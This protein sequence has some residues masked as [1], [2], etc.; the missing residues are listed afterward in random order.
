MEQG[1]YS[2]DQEA[3]D[4]IIGRGKSSCDSAPGKSQHVEWM[5]PK[6]IRFS[7]RPVFEKS[8]ALLRKGAGKEGS[9][10]CFA[11]VAAEGSLEGLLAKLRDGS[12][13]VEEVPPIR[14]FYHEN[15]WYTLDNR[16]LWVFRELGKRI[17]VEVVEASK[18][19]L[20][21][22]EPK[23]A[24]REVSFRNPGMAAE[25]Q[26]LSRQVLAW[27]LDNINNESLLVNQVD[28]IPLEFP[29]LKN[30]LSVF[31]PL[32][33]EETR[34]ALQQSLEMINELPCVLVEMGKE[35]PVRD[36]D[37][38]IRR[39]KMQ[40]S[41]DILKPKDLVLLTTAEP[42]CLT[43]LRDSGEFYT[44]GLIIAGDDMD[45]DEL[46]VDVYAPIDSSEYD[47][48]LETNRP[49]YAVYLS[50]L[51]TG[52]RV[53]ESLKRPSLALA[54]Q[55][56]IFQEV[57]QANSGEPEI[58]DVEGMTSS[59]I[60]CARW[61][62]LNDSQMEAVSRTVIALKREQKPY[63]RLIQGPPGTGKTSML[64]ALISVLAG[65][66]K[67]ILMSAPTNAAI[68]EVVVRLFTSITKQPSP[69]IGCT[70][71]VCPRDVV[72]VGNKEN[73]EV[74][75]NEILDAV[76]LQSREERLATVLAT[77]CG[78]QQK[79][80]SVVDFLENA[81]ER[82]RQYKQDK[83]PDEPAESF[84]DFSRERMTFL[85][86]Q[87]LSSID[88]VCNDLPSTFLK[89]T[90][91]LGARHHVTE[92]NAAFGRF[93]EDS[94][95]LNYVSSTSGA[96][97]ALLNLLKTNMDFVTYPPGKIP[98]GEE[99]LRHASVVCCTV[100]SAGTRIV[101]NTS[102]H[103][104]TA[105]IDEAGQLVE[106][107]TA[108]VMGLQNLKQLV[109]V[110]DHKQLP[111]TVI[112]KIAQDYSYGR[113]LFERLQLL[114]HP[115]IML[116]VQYRMH[117][118]ISQFPNFQF[119]EGAICDGPNVVDDFYGQLSQSQ[120]FGP[121]TFLNVHG[122]ET[123]DEKHSKSNAVEV[124]VVMHLLKMLHQSGEKLQVGIISPYA[125]QVK[126]INDRLKSWDHGSLSINC[127]S[128]DGFQGREKDVIILSTVRSNVGGYLGF[129]ED[130]RRL[131]VA[132]TRARHVLCI[133][134]NANTLESSDGVWRQLLNDARHRKCY[135]EASQD[136]TVK[137]TIQRAM[138]EIHQLESLVD[139]RSD[140]F[141]NNVWKV[142]FSKEF[143]ASFTSIS[144]GS[145]KLH[146]LNAILN[147][148]NGRRPRHA[149]TAPV[150]T[151]RNYVQFHLTME[152][153]L[154]WTVDLDADCTVQ[155][156]KFWDVLKLDGLPRIVSRLEN[157]CATYSGPYLRRSSERLTD[158]KVAVPAR[159]SSGAEIE[160]HKS[161]KEIASSE[162]NG[163][164]TTGENSSVSESLL[165]M[166]FY[167]LSTGIARQLL[168]ATD[169][170]QIDPPFEV[171]D[172]ES[173]VVKFPWS[174]FVV[175][176]SG[177]GK[178]TVI[179]MKLLNREQ[180]FRLSHGLAEGESPGQTVVR[181]ALITVSS[182]LCAA[183]KFHLQRTRR[184]LQ[185]NNA[186]NKDDMYE[187][188][189][190]MLD[191][192]AEEKLFS[193][194]PDSFV[195]ISPQALPLVIT[196]RKFL[197]MLDGSVPRPFI[198]RR[199]M[200]TA[201]GT[202]IRVEDCDDS[203][204]FD[205][206]D[207]I[208][209]SYEAPK[210]S[211]R[212]QR[213]KEVDFDCFAASYW[214]HLNSSFT[215]MFDASVVFTEIMSSIK[216][217][218]ESL[219]SHKGRLS[220]NDYVYMS[221]YTLDQSQRENI[222]EL[223][224]QYE[225]LK[226]QRDEYDILDHVRYL[227]RQIE[228]GEPLGPKFQFIYVDEVQDLTLAQISLLK[229]V[230]DNVAEGFVFAG[231]TAQTIAKGVN[232][233]FEDI[234]SLFYKEFLEIDD[235]RQITKDGKLRKQALCNIHQLTQN[236]R[237]HKGIVDLADSIMQLLL[238]FFPETVD[239][240]EPE[241]SLICGEKPV[242]VKSDENYNLITC[243][244][245][246]SGRFGRES[247]FGAEQSNFGSKWR[248]LYT[249]LDETSL[250]NCCCQGYPKFEKRLHNILCNELKQL[251]VAITRSKQRLWIYDEDFTFQQPMLD[252][253][254]TKNLV[255][256]RS[257]DESLVSSFHRI[258]TREEWLQRGRQ[259][260]NDRQYDMAVLCY[261][262]AHDSY[263]AQWAQAALHQQNGEK[264]LVWNPTIATQQLQDAVNLYERIAKFEAAARCL[265]KIKNFKQAGVLYRDKC[266][267]SRW[268]NAAQ[269][270]EQAKIY[271][272]AAEAYAMVEDFQSCLSACLAGKLFEKGLNFIRDR[273]QQ[274]ASFLSNKYVVN[275][276]KTSAEH[277]HRKK[278]VD[279]MMK[280]VHAFP[281]ISMKRD[282]LKRRDYLEQ[283][284]QVEFFYMNYEEASQVAEA[285]GDL[286]AAAKFLELAGHR[287]EGARKII[288][289]M[290]LKLL[291][292]N[293]NLGWPLRPL[294]DEKLVTEAHRMAKGDPRAEIQL[295]VLRDDDD[296]SLSDVFE[297]W[298]LA[299]D[300]PTINI[301]V[302]RQLLEKGLELAKGST[303][304]GLLTLQVLDRPL[305]TAS[306]MTNTLQ[307][308][309]AVWNT[310]FQKISS[311]LKALAKIEKIIPQG[312][313]LLDSCLEFMGVTRHHLPGLCIVEDSMV[314]WLKRGGDWTVGSG[315]AQLK[316]EKFLS[317]ATDF[318]RGQLESTSAIFCE[319]L[320]S[321]AGNAGGAESCLSVLKIMDVVSSLGKSETHERRLRSLRMELFR[322]LFVRRG[323]TPV[324]LR[325]H[326]KVTPHL[327]ALARDI[328]AASDSVEET[329]MLQILGPY[330]RN[331]P[332]QDFIANE[333]CYHFAMPI[334]QCAQGLHDI[335][336]MEGFQHYITPSM[337]IYMLERI[338]VS[339]TAC[340]SHI[341]EATLPE[342][343]AMEFMTGSTQEILYT[344]MLR[345]G[346]SVDKFC[347]S[348]GTNSLEVIQK[349]C[350]SLLLGYRLDK[351]L[352]D[353]PKSEVVFRI[354]RVLLTI[355][356]EFENQAV[357]SHIFRDLRSLVTRQSS[358]LDH[359]LP[360][361]RQGLQC[362][363]ETGANYNHF[364]ILFCRFMIECGDQ[365]LLLRRRDKFRHGFK[366]RF[367]TYVNVEPEPW[368]FSL[369]SLQQPDDLMLQTVDAE[370][371]EVD[372]TTELKPSEVELT[373]E[374]PEPE[375]TAPAKE[376]ALSPWYLKVGDS[377]LGFFV[378]WRLLK[379][380]QVARENLVQDDEYVREAKNAFSTMACKDDGYVSSFIS[381]VCPL[382]ADLVSFVLDMASAIEILKG[383]TF[384]GQDGQLKADRDDLVEKMNDFKCECE[385]LLEL[386]D[387]RHADHQKQDL[388]WL[389]LSVTNPATEKLSYGRSKFN[390]R[391]K[392][393]LGDALQRKETISNE[394]AKPCSS[395]TKP[396]PKKSN[397][398]KKSG[399]KGGRKKQ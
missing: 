205:T 82:Y 164:T 254:I 55:Y 49:W 279:R 101:Q 316:T 151:K 63:V 214:P 34:A 160:R 317:L 145:T 232:F 226:S 168:T 347:K 197:T 156:L 277:Y 386:M 259:M 269:C 323:N 326:P 100:S 352:L 40:V 399:K 308:V 282:F 142:F 247:D 310:W 202:F 233:R 309:V 258:S 98:T 396:A 393:V 361:L 374:C 26:T 14:V 373:F 50:S 32:L 243:L 301:I 41:K 200:E 219:R 110:G 84:L 213:R 375:M 141:S 276:L 20:K 163:E 372:E 325:D 391:L 119:Y 329:V 245:D 371:E 29:A 292:A 241:R 64:M 166:K 118:S 378:V 231:D 169:G 367:Q 320:E 338:L 112:S 392:D 39:F 3:P 135:R 382:K 319:V 136:S 293:N 215:K 44:L 134:G 1:E 150:P 114:G 190:L 199:D 363:F 76:F 383:R 223:F 252:Y 53:W 288:K 149:F 358:A 97:A 380:L 19:F 334:S 146:V 224:L 331:G 287:A 79:V 74:D 143:K 330:L 18:E 257:L 303:S 260:F 89:S 54:S 314:D 394:P 25:E 390:H 350:S 290:Q 328:T 70:R 388:D 148:A 337:F 397:K 271:D 140:F 267:P 299:K 181:Q 218:P 228:G 315:K 155:V 90:D 5:D 272:E 295:R 52:M 307:F 111:A 313:A 201:Q 165:L 311:L 364:R 306:D 278:D 94:E 286:I 178:T 188:E 191:E 239:K 220:R 346:C 336:S 222:Y 80:L 356:M 17:P 157:L 284:M 16:R 177:T 162:A 302:L 237:T 327:D 138:A 176:R 351:W 207:D 183:I 381:E 37:D 369:A 21:K 158:G 30:Y 261:Q 131:N 105:V 139:P 395:A 33:L 195:D 72:L 66:S 208:D 196:Y 51:A 305:R 366:S 152:M 216:G 362:L 68:T 123:K 59:E 161:L 187:R 212:I 2:S 120:L 85:G 339:S 227:Y 321:H 93:R 75:D 133:V 389:L 28:K 122:V 170:S 43:I 4:A 23:F 255:Q 365:F 103:F 280:F 86:D 398:K 384:A 116:N 83:K 230:S 154:V 270:F 46:K 24:G 345:M 359:L 88:L 203:D 322:C 217:R 285:K 296:L 36:G 92:I 128:V 244:F 91:I 343:L 56:P 385:A 13:G 121:Y 130:H 35:V 312:D 275:L 108:I 265:T 42:D 300:D 240:L 77:A 236:F 355:F 206:N 27:S 262:R 172:Q 99:L 106:A 281:G 104:Y 22:L 291:W 144:S 38:K 96:A 194:I 238:F 57:L 204:R 368:K 235:R 357:N 174:S 344:R 294:E 263:R 11:Q 185:R 354:I 65:S 167:S 273:E 264:N 102:R 225:K 132:I 180:Q 10:Q 221:S 248:T 129:L 210:T 250:V 31:R 175:G 266:N 332:G 298:K 12:V 335:F 173:Q 318:W 341:V 95:V 71:T 274:D 47:P 107:E 251:Y 256:S 333:Y 234:R 349:I 9:S 58:Y 283:L 377:K 137:R 353:I 387:P 69:F 8:V 126:A 297:N 304:L 370:E 127:R 67:R 268:E 360:S 253:W 324:S 6:S 15:A 182:K 48:F 78:W 179:T 124:L 242:V 186:V 73:L 113:S 117:P 171:T 209:I 184:S 289:H 211:Q 125:A 348:V 193:D 246:R 115:S 153:Y 87:M 60:S 379:K 81:E 249:Y 45:S 192:E 109:L 61:F 376:E 62:K 342:S 7:Q 229:F 198:A 147:L 189:G 340:L 159:W